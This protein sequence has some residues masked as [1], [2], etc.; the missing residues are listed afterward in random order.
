[1]WDDHDITD[2]WGSREDSFIK[3]TNQ[4]SDNWQ[5]LFDTAKEVFSEMQAS[6][7]P[8]KLSSHGF[9]TA[10]KI[11]RAGFILADLR[12]NRNIRDQEI[13]LDSQFLAVYKWIECHRKNIDILF[14]ISPVVF[15]HGA[16]VIENTIL[17]KWPAIH[18]FFDRIWEIQNSFS[19]QCK[20]Y[21]GLILGI[22]L[23]IV[24]CSL[25]FVCMD[26]SF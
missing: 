16:P 15:A 20:E 1:M 21:H 7:N 4:F 9:D 24:F 8:D 5:N 6:R 19:R 18:A 25:L 3:D 14:F 23:L 26:E 10:F 22:L 2:G 12:S 13:W 11:G 17:K